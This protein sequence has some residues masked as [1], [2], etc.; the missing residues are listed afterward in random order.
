MRFEVSPTR[1]QGPAR[2][3]VGSTGTAFYIM[4]GRPFVTMRTYR[5]RKRDPDS[6]IAVEL[7]REL[8]RLA[9]SFPRFRLALNQLQH[10]VLVQVRTPAWKAKR[11]LECVPTQK[12][13]SIRELVKT[14]ELDFVSV[15]NT[16]ASLRAAG[17]VITCNRAGRPVHPTLDTALPGIANAIEP[18][19]IGDWQ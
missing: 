15:K 4:R 16:L 14:T 1:S 6:Q 11:I 9:D 10:R 8:T 18:G 5:E 7:S 19:R 2:R 13:I 12:G 17:E 3:A